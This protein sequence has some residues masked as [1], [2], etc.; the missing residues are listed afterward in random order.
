[1]VVVPTDTS[2]K[3]SYG[4]SGIE[5]ISLV[6]T[7]VGIADLFA[8]RRIP[9]VTGGRLWDLGSSPL[10]LLPSRDLVL[11]EVHGAISSVGR[12]PRR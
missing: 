4:R 7:I 8:L 5:R 2:V 10:D 6:L 9:V 1:M 11:A 3:L 12:S